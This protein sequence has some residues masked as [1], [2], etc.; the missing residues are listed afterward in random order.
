MFLKALAGAAIAFLFAMICFV[1]GFVFAEPG[2]PRTLE[3]KDC[4]IPPPPPRTEPPH[5]T[6]QRRTKGIA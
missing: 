6:I 4:R 1:G 3:L 2:V 5:K